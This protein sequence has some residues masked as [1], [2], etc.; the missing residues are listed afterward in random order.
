MGDDADV[1]FAIS[2][3]KVG[4]K[5]GFSSYRGDRLGYAENSASL[6]EPPVCIQMAMHTDG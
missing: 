1:G 5:E 4:K 3:R 6:Q 2:K